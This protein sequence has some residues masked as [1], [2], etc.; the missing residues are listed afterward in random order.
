VQLPAYQTLNSTVSW[1]LVPKKVQVFGAV[2]NLFNAD[3][4]EVIGYNAKG[5]NVKLGL[6]FL[7]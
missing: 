5:R 7:F 1:D 3:F 6:S 2:T 4:Q